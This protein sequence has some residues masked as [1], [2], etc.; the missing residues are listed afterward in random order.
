M[1]VALA[2]A[3]ELNVTAERISKVKIQFSEPIDLLII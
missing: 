3:E 2:I 1:K